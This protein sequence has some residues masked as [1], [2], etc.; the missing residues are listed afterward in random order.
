MH[1]LVPFDTRQSNLACYNPLC[2]RGK[3]VADQ[4]RPIPKDGL[5]MG[6]Q[7]TAILGVHILTATPSDVE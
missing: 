3:L 1:T 5:G 6:L 7:C 4:A 2:G